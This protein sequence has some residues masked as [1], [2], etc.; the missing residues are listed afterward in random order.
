MSNIEHAL[1]QAAEPSLTTWQGYGEAAARLGRW[2][3]VFRRLG[4]LVLDGVLMVAGFWA[5]ITLRYFGISS[6]IVGLL[7]LAYAIGLFLYNPLMEVFLGGSIGKKVFRLTVVNQEGERISG[8]Q[9]FIRAAFAL[10]EF[11]PLLLA[12]LFSGLLVLVTPTRQRIGD[13]YAKTFV[14][15]RANLDRARHEHMLKTFG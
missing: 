1:P 12:G 8:G 13:I 4:G 6:F 5:I 2:T 7:L 15:S 11:S 9:A 10:A 3:M 14:V